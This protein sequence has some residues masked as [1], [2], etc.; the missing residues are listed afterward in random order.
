MSEESFNYVGERF[1]DLQMLRYRL[2]DFD[3]L[4]LRQKSLIYCLAKATLYGRDITFDEFGKYNLKIRK[5]LE[6]VFCLYKVTATALTLRL[7]QFI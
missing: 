3:K 5:T 7:L 2:D 4:T 1:A 6:A